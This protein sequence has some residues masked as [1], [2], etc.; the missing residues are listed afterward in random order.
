MTQEML[1]FDKLEAL[2]Y[3]RRNTIIGACSWRKTIS[4][5]FGWCDNLCTELLYRIR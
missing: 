3:T 2:K 1:I 5:G 4:V